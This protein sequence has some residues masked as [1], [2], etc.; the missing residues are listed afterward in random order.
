MWVQKCACTGVDT[1]VWVQVCA[2]M[3]VYRCTCQGVGY[4]D[5]GNVCECRSV[6]FNVL[7]TSVGVRALVSRFGCTC[8][9]VQI[10]CA[11]SDVKEKEAGIVGVT[12]RSDTRDSHIGKSRWRKVTMESPF[13]AAP[14]GD[15]TS[16][17]PS[18]YS[19][20]GHAS[21]NC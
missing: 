2:L 6:L 21:V 1:K 16:T 11:I 19:L 10:C 7:Y 20:W 17:Y 4:T 18:C 3:R 14:T 12:I 5:M 13:F 8:V 15:Q 9:G